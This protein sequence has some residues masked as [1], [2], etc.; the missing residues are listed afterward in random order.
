MQVV[1]SLDTGSGQIDLHDNASLTT[2]GSP[3]TAQAIRDQVREIR[4]YILAQDGQKDN[5]FTYPNQKVTVGETLNGTL[6][7]REFDLATI[8]SDWSHYR[9]K[10]YTIVVQPKSLN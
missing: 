6:Y 7:G 10:I 2:L 4:I 3:P 9:W 5:R 8:G 1:Y